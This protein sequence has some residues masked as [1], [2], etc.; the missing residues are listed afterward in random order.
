MY[1][2]Y[3]KLCLPLLKLTSHGNKHSYDTGEKKIQP[4]K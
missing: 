3:G 1:T 4:H 2:M